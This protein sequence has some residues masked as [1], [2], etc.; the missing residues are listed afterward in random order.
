MEKLQQM[1]NKLFKFLPKRPV[2]SMAFQNPPPLSPSGSVT[3]KACR[4]RV[5]IIPKEARRK[6]RT[7]SFSK[8]EPTSPKVSCIGQVEGKKMRKVQK[9]KKVQAKKSDNVPQREKKKTLLWSF[10]ENGESPKQRDEAPSA[11]SP[12]PSLGTMKK[13]SGGRKSM[14]DFGITIVER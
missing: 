10:T 6:H 4:N 9:Q 1:K 14:A 12:A 13:F 11:M 5:S 2:A 8:R 7:G 3:T